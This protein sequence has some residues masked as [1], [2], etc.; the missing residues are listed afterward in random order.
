MA[1]PAYFNTEEREATDTAG[2]ELVDALEALGITELDD[3]H[4]VEP[5]PDPH[6]EHSKD[7]F[8]NLGNYRPDTL[9]AVVTK[10]RA[11]AKPQ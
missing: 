3:M 5:C 4:I 9:R 2:R 8:L 6:C 11:L 7:T 1:H 10:L